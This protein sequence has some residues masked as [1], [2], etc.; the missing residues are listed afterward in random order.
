MYIKYYLLS[1]ADTLSFAETS[2]LIRSLY[3]NK[4]L[5]SIFSDT[6]RLK[7]GISRTEVRG[8]EGTTYQK[9]KIYLDGYTRVSSWIASG[10][11]PDKLLF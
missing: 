11:N 2:D 9:D 4:S 8:V 6:V 10:G 1:A 5:E 7:R 3:P